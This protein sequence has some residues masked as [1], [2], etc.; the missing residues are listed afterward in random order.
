MHDKYDCCRLQFS[1][2][3]IVIDGSKSALHKD[4][5]ILLDRELTLLRTDYSIPAVSGFNGTSELASRMFKS[6]KFMCDNLCKCR[7]HIESYVNANL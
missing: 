7:K 3:A 2:T 6:A 5:P 1:V 4:K